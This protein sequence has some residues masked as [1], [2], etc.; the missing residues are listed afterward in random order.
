MQ[1]AKA[2]FV[3]AF[4][5]TT[6]PTANAAPPVYRQIGEYP[7]FVLPTRKQQSSPRLWVDARRGWVVKTGTVGSVIQ[8]TTDGGR[9]WR[10]QTVE[11]PDEYAYAN[12]YSPRFFGPGLHHG[13]FTADLEHGN[14]SVNYV[15]HDDGKRWAIAQPARRKHR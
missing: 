1:A 8:R 14:H 5:W 13:A 2:V 15:T 11:L 3:A 9:M 6:M 4:L 10:V 12:T 7:R